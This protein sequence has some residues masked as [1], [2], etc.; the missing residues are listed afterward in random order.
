MLLLLTLFPLALIGAAIAI[1]DDD[2]DTP[3][4]SDDQQV[5]GTSADDVIT[6]ATGDDIVTG[7]PGDDTLDGAQGSDIIIGDG[8]LDQIRGGDGND[9]LLGRGGGDVVEGNAGDDWVEGDGGDDTVTGGRGADTVIGSEGA[10]LIIGGNDD[11]VLIDGVVPGTPLDTATLELLRG[12]TSLLDIVGTDPL[13]LTD[14]LDADTLNG[15]DGADVLIFG[16]GDIASGEGGVDDFAMVT[17][18]AAS[19]LD[20][21]RILDFE[22]TTE[23]FA[24]IVPADT[25][26]M[27]TVTVQTQGLDAIVSVDGAELATIVGAA[28]QIDA[29]DISIFTGVAPTLLD[30]KPPTA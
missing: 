16:K 2:D 10:D 1:A 9:L 26:V 4:Q 27:P 13:S 8:G 12:G 5:E 25:A 23:T 18:G 11:D 30:P 3:Q 14:D 21:A 17:D 7:G 20:T 6:T 29:A 19:A 22:P 28:G 24:L 15:N